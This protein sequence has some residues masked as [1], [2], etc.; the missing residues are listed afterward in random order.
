ML[1]SLGF[2]SNLVI[3]VTAGV[4]QETGALAFPGVSGNDSGGGRGG[5]GPPPTPRAGSGR[6]GRNE[7]WL[8]STCL[9]QPHRSLHWA[10]TSATYQPPPHP[11]KVLRGRELWGRGWARACARTCGG[12]QVHGQGGS[13]SLRLPLSHSLRPSARAWRSRG[14]VLGRFCC[15]KQTSGIQLQG[16]LERPQTAHG[17]LTV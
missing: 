9:F 16:T 17:K 1:P 11:E 12:A 5:A 6:P 8:P 14:K 13:P 15:A 2:C 7:M 10:L 3:R 4:A